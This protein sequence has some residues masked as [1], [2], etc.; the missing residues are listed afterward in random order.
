VRFGYHLT[1]SPEKTT[2]LQLTAGERGGGARDER[3]NLSIASR[4]LLAFFLPSFLSFLRSRGSAGTCVHAHL[5]PPKANGRG[6][7]CRRYN[8]T[9][10]REYLRDARDVT[11]FAFRRDDRIQLTDPEGCTSKGPRALRALL[12]HT[13]K[14]ACLRSFLLFYFFLFAFGTKQHARYVK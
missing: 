2:F 8:T 5:F 4:D 12:L 14:Y 13:L 3:E 11:A 9:F 6:V 10:K 1:D 7:N